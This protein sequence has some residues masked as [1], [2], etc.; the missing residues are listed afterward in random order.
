MLKRL[1]NTQTYRVETEKAVYL[2][3]IKSI[4]NDINGNPRYNAN[5]ILFEDKNEANPNEHLYFYT[6]QY[7]FTGHYCGWNGEA[8]YIV[9]RFEEE[10]YR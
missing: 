6:A 5:I 10:S 3:N 1:D 7:N 4:K 2:V 8:E 9:R